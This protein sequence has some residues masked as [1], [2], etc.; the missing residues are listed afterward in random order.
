MLVLS[1]T[2]LRK[3]VARIIFVGAVHLRSLG[4]LN[5]C[6]PGRCAVVVESG[7][8][9]IWFDGDDIP[10]ITGVE[11]RSQLF[12]ADWVRADIKTNVTKA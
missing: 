5:C 1:L 4:P 11:R 9:P 8:Q 10:S 7:L 3:R 2:R 12:L 6:E